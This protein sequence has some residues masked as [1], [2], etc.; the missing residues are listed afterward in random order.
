M[1]I[2]STIRGGLA[3]I[4]NYWVGPSSNPGPAIDPIIADSDRV[5]NKQNK[6]DLYRQAKSI[7]GI[8]G[9]DEANPYGIPRPTTEKPKNTE[10]PKKDISKGTSRPKSMQGKENM[11]LQGFDVPYSKPYSEPD[12]ADP[13]GIKRPNLKP[14]KGMSQYDGIGQ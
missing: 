5:A 12:Q 2:K 11:N 13:Q 14:K 1:G 8:Q 6:R 9:K 7:Q 4:K 10:K 3:G